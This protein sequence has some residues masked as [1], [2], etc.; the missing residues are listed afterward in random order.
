MKNDDKIQL[1][2]ELIGR[3][4]NERLTRSQI[5]GSTFERKHEYRERD[6]GTRVQTRKEYTE[7]DWSGSSF[8]GRTFG[9]SGWGGGREI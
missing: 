7:R 2:L 5:P 9:G 6:Y 4:G 8:G 1:A 3:A